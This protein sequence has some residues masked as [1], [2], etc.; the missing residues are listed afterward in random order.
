MRVDQRQELYEKLMEGA[1]ETPDAMVE[2]AEVV[3]H[4]LDQIE[5]IID[6]MLRQ[7]GGESA[8]PLDLTS[9]ELLLTVTP[10]GES[11]YV[12]LAVGK[13]KVRAHIDRT[14]LRSLC[15]FLI[16]ESGG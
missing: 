6:E 11:C 15:D 4:D 2:L 3:T 14:R 1:P 10:D 9:A 8:L 16:H 7:A 5:P 13:M 12:D